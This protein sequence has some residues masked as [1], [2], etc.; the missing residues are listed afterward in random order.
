[1]AH[2]E[3]ERDYDEDPHYYFLTNYY[4]T[5]N[6]CRLPKTEAEEL[7]DGT[8]ALNMEEDRAIPKKDWHK[9]FEAAQ[10]RASELI[11][12]KLLSLDSQKARLKARDPSSEPVTEITFEETE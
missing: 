5:L 1:M 12:N 4:F 3:Y 7:E 2:S 9:S 10:E 6:I 8:L 11:G